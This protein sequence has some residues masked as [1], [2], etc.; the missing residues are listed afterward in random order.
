MKTLI[1]L[2]CLFSLSFAQYDSWGKYGNY[3]TRAD[4]CTKYI[5][6]DANTSINDGAWHY[7]GAKRDGDV[8]SLTIDNGTPVTNTGA[9]L[10]DL[11]NPGYDFT[12]GFRAPGSLYN[13]TQI[14]NIRVS[15]KARSA[16][17]IAAYWNSVQ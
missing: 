3:L 5:A 15:D 4:E 9:D 12:I 7:A 17:E 16:S 8:T 13:G 6:S 11:D 14:S 10:L 2:L 1:I